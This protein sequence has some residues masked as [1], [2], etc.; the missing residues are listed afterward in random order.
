M[1]KSDINLSQVFQAIAQESQDTPFVTRLTPT[2]RQMLGMLAKSYSLNM[3]EVVRRL[4]HQA[5]V[6]YVNDDEV[7]ALLSYQYE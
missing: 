4:I 1:K 5:V 7:M 2:E 3:T 6:D